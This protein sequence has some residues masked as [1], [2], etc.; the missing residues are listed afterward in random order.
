LTQLA[1]AARMMDEN[2]RNTFYE[3]IQTRFNAHEIDFIQTK[4]LEGE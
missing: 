1:D 2:G 3:A 4:V